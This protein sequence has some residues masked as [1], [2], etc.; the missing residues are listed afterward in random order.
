MKQSLPKSKTPIFVWRASQPTS[1]YLGGKCLF[2]NNE[3]TTHILGDGERDTKLEG[4]FSHEMAE[5]VTFKNKGQPLSEDDDFWEMCQP[6]KGTCKRCGWWINYLQ[7]GN[8]GS[9]RTCSAALLEFEIN[10][11]NLALPEILSHLSKNFSDV[12]SLSSRR[13]EELVA[14]VYRSIG[15]E[16][17]LTKQSRDGGVDIFCIRHSSGHSCI[18]ECKR[19]SSDNSVGIDVVDRLIGVSFRLGISEA[20][21]V[22]SSRFTHPAKSAANMAQHKSLEMNLVDAH[23]LL[24]M[25]NVFADPSLTVNNITSIF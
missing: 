14:H 1:G 6:R 9:E 7:Y 19:Y 24:R 18:V 15:W 3:L 11:A 17:A 5:W 13:F 2:C 25:F 12:H 23:E 22:T 20:H 10:D 4:L 8:V 16:V 21:I